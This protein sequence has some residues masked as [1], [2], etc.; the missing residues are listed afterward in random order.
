MPVTQHMSNDKTRA[1]WIEDVRQQEMEVGF[2]TRQHTGAV[3]TIARI[4]HNLGLELQRLE[5]LRTRFQAWEA[6]RS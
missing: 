5:L 1:D 4:D 2:W 6:E 3:E